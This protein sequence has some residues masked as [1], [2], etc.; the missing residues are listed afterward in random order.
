M[1]ACPN[2]KASIFALATLTTVV[3]GTA[4]AAPS[5]NDFARGISLTA[6][7]ERPLQTLI[8]PDEVYATVTKSNLD[9]IRVFNADGIAVPHAVCPQTAEQE[10]QDRP[11]AA[12]PLQTARP[13]TTASTSSANTDV[14]VSPDGQI[15]IK[16][17]QADDKPSVKQSDTSVS[18]FVIDARDVKETITGIR[19]R[20][21][22]TDGASEMK[23][24]VQSSADLNRWR[25]IV[26]SATLLQISGK[27]FAPQRT[28]VDLP[29]AGY[30]YLRLE[31]IGNGPQPVLRDVIA[32]VL[33]PSAKKETRKFPAQP[34]SE[35][36]KPIDEADKTDKKPLYFETGRNTMINKAIVQLPMSNMSLQ[37]ALDSRAKTDQRWQQRWQGE[38]HSIDAYAASNPSFAATSDRHW[39]MRIPVGIET[40]GGARPSL[41]FG[42]TPDE[43]HFLAQ[44]TGP[45]LL[46]FGSQTAEKP[47]Q[48]CGRLLQ[49]VS[50]DDR[51]HLTGKASV[52]GVM[53][54]LV[55]GDQQLEPVP[56]AT[57]WMRILLWVLLI[58]GTVLLILMALSLMKQLK[59][60]D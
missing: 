10:K 20:W 51:K 26:A 11:L 27:K 12:F 14:R 15:D 42:Y 30:Q 23:V 54:A 38:I 56:E 8:I 58:G 60:N 37:V 49:N 44:G 6:Q 45:Y 5:A 24:R 19:L 48:Q 16:V 7:A 4:F 9:D 31:R 2:I 29:K 50:Q 39:R 32:E 41:S 43:L 46:A 3:T 57:P 1:T 55:G 28:R 34:L 18:G 33:L 47:A 40:L 17:R 25:T 35:I 21:H 13:Q 53:D 36:D 52:V 22:A 59:K